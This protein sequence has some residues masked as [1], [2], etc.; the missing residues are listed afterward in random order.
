VATT[1]LTLEFRPIRGSWGT[2]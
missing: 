2:A 1:T